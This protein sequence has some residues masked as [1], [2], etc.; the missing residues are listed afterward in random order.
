MNFNIGTLPSFSQG[1]KRRRE[2][3]QPLLY[4]LQFQIK[5]VQIYEITYFQVVQK[6]QT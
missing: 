5:N 6:I 1:E 3:E 4:K 2:K